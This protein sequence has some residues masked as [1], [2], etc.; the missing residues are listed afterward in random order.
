MCFP[1]VLCLN[2][3]QFKNGEEIRCLLWECMRKVEILNF[4]KTLQTTTDAFVSVKE[5]LGCYND[6]IQSIHHRA[7][8]LMHRICRLMPSLNRTVLKAVFEGVR[9]YSHLLCDYVDCVRYK[10]QQRIS[11][12]LFDH[13]LYILKTSLKL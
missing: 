2:R 9:E 10:K 5:L 1:Y 13:Q 4:E 8:K 6:S 7:C 12:V 3:K 11:E